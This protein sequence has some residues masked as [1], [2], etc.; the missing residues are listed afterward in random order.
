MTK[1]KYIVFSILCIVLTSCNTPVMHPW[2]IYGNNHQVTL[3]ISKWPIVSQDVYVAVPKEKILD[4]EKLLQDQ[5]YIEIT[6]DQEKI[7]NKH[8]PKPKNPNLK[9]YLI[10]GVTMGTPLFSILKKNPDTNEIAIY[11]ARWNGE[12]TIPFVKPKFGIWPV[13]I[14][15]DKPPQRI[16]P[17]AVYGGDWIMRD[18]ENSDTRIIKRKEK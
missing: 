10:R 2:Q 3:N 6:S 1:I 4:A 11:R 17:T 18:Y 12:I 5:E 8:L 9:P 7:F 13:V 14:Y 15:L 16:Y